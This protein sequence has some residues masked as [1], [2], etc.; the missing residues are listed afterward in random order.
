LILEI[1]LEDLPVWEDLSSLEDFWLIVCKARSN[2]GELDR[3]STQFC[4]C[5][6]RYIYI[7]ASYHDFIGFVEEIAYASSFVGF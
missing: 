1:D 7:T 4:I 2:S 5:E 3:D 6:K